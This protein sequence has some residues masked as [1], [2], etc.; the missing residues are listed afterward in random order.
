MEEGRT[1]GTKRGEKRWKMRS[2]DSIFDEDTGVM[3]DVWDAN[4]GIGAHLCAAKVKMY[5][6][7]C[8]RMEEMLQKSKSKA[9]VGFSCML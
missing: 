6:G 8:V 2:K 4:V 1:K 3:A 7:P 5:D 9:Q